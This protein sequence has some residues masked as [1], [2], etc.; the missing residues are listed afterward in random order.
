MKEYT[1][2]LQTCDDALV[3]DA[4]HHG[5]KHGAEIETQ[6][7]KASM[8]MYGYGGGETFQY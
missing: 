5:G 4:D 3:I 2:C 7:Q 8:A 6:K 1:K